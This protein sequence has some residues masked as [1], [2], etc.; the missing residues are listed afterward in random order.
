M[1]MLKSWYSGELCANMDSKTFVLF[2]FV[3]WNLRH[4][5]SSFFYWC[6]CP[7]ILFICSHSN[8]RPIFVFFFFWMQPWPYV[9]NDE[10]SYW[11]KS[12]D[13][14]QKVCRSSVQVACR[15]Y[16][17]MINVD[18][19]LPTRPA[20]V[21]YSGPAGRGIYQQGGH[22]GHSILV[23]T[24]VDTS[25]RVR[26][27][28]ATTECVQS[29]GGSVRGRACNLP[30]QASPLWPTVFASSSG[31]SKT[32]QRHVGLQRYLSIQLGCHCNAIVRVRGGRRLSVFTIT[33]RSC[34][35]GVSS[36]LWYPTI[37]VHM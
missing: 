24:A 7:V 15:Q 30:D 16:P 18:Q 12:K 26:T 22:D 5:Q 20:A 2:F 10:T 27:Y 3:E 11:Q 6:E 4:Y 19:Q 34:Q 36:H 37:L 23:V 35:N 25:R 28:T 21:K 9:Q 14:T 8:C 31:G 29:R 13:C 32:D 33:I 1:V 17:V